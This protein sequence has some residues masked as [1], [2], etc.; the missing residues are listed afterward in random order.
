MQRGARRITSHVPSLVVLGLLLAS[1]TASA[2]PP[3][4]KECIAAADDGQKLRDDGKLVSARD[5]FILCAAKSC[6][7]VVAKQCNQWLSDAE[8]EMPS[9]TFRAI[10]DNGKETLEVKVSIDDKVVAQSIE[11]KAVAVDPGEHKVKFEKADGISVED[12]ILLRPGEKNRLIELSFQ[13]KAPPPPVAET[14]KPV[15]PVEPAPEPSRGFRIPTLGWVG[16]GVFAAGGITTIAFASMANGDESDLRDRCAPT[17]PESE[18]SG[19]DTKI[20]IANVG[21]FVGLAGLGLAVVTTVLENTGGKPAEKPQA[22]PLSTP[23]PAS[24]SITFDVG[25]TGALVRGAF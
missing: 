19:I 12:K 5:K 15:P 11:A 20:A 13:T 24:A 18:K 14:P 17:C 1:T 16:L 25:P 10:D 6:P 8:R 9:V 21:L 4:Q 23:K 3:T 22:R 2:A 7:N